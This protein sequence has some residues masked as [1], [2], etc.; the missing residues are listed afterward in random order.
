VS[1]PIRVGIVG[2]SGYAAA[3]HE[4]LLKLE[5]KRQVRVVATCDPARDALASR[6]PHWRLRERGVYLLSDYKALIEAAGRFL[7]VLVVPGS[8]PE[9][10]NIYRAAHAAGIPVYF[11]KM[12]TLDHRELDAMAAL[13]RTA[14]KAS[15]VGFNFVAAPLR[16]S[17]KSR[18]LAG[19]FGRLREVRLQAI[20]SRPT[21]YF[22][23]HE[24]A[25]RL[26]RGG[27]FVLDSCLGH[28]FGHFVQNALR[29]AQADESQN[30]P[31][32]A[33]LRAELY[34][35]HWIESYDTV[36]LE[37]RTTSGVTLRMALSLAHAGACANTEFV[38][39]ENAT[40]ELT[41]GQGAK[42]NWHGGR[43]ESLSAEPE[44][45]LVQ[46]HSAYARY[47]RGETIAP[48]SALDA[49][50]ALV[51][52]TNLAFVSS[53]VITPIVPERVQLTRDPAE[54]TDY[55]VVADLPR[56]LSAFTERGTW[57]SISEWKRLRPSRTV[58]ESDLNG[59]EPTV[60]SLCG[61][62]PSAV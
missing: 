36:C 16:A 47:L 35:A 60:R 3:H 26:L 40:V 48:P 52:L 12:P 51:L 57:P 49:C 23:R 61:L 7:D 10:R 19:E 62:N 38:V 9:R 37:T 2:M 28:E 24:R 22:S 33:S 59:F 43:I 53:E 6:H 17:L 1:D 25:G 21:V 29:W 45:P 13:E 14:T 30:S 50:R 32:L 31:T 44:D 42:I 54:Q 27:E 20:W 39:C 15:N 41:P 58:S 5:E 4:A 11:D 55:L 56:T 18:L 8:E 34:R 46:N